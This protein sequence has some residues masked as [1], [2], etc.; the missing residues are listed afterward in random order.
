MWLSARRGDAVKQLAEEINGSGGQAHAQEVDA[1]SPDA[2]EAYLATIA[3]T[4]T[5]DIVFNGIGVAPTESGYPARSLDQELDSFL[6]PMRMT[7]GSQF[8]TAR[9]AARH[10]SKRGTGSIVLI[11]SAL[12]RLSIPHQAGT[13]A[14]SAAVEAMTRSLAAEFGPSGIRVNCVRDQRCRRLARSARR[15]LVMRGSPGPQQRLRLR[16]RRQTRLDGR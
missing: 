1:L 10:M 6:G 16:F 8:L 11:S 15:G 9:E 12:S 7:V 5:V 4:A 2:V 14:A 13:S 3:A